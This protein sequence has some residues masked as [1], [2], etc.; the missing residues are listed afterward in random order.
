MSVSVK[1]DFFRECQYRFAAYIRNPEHKPV[2]RGIEKRRMDLYRELMFNNVEGFLSNAFPVLRQVL[3]DQSWLEMARDFFARHRCKTPYF[4]EIPEEF[5]EYLQKERGDRPDKF[6][7]LVELAHYEW[8]ELALALAEDEQAVNRDASSTVSLSSRY[9][10]SDLAWPLVYSYPVHKISK[11]FTPLHPPEQPTY[12]V[13]YRN[14][15]DDVKFMEINGAT[16]RFL[17]LLD[18]NEEPTAEECVEQLSKEFLHFEKNR[19]ACYVGETLQ[20][21]Q[22]RG[23]VHE[24]SG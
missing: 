11:S 12:L 20:S 13:V 3:D 18:T 5:L 24:I 10:L 17:Q 1:R 16:F 23:I 6:P 15:E 19:I 8:V 22:I 7:F 9:C 21:L 2:P 14:P 4:S